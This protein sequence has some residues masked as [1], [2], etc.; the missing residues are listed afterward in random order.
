MDHLLQLSIQINPRDEDFCQP[1][2]ARS[3]PIFNFPL[4]SFLMRVCVALAT[5]VLLLP[6]YSIMYKMTY[7][8][9]FSTTF[10]LSCMIFSS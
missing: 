5:N 10:S 1:F 2:A 6:I 4:F 8:N 9:G 7:P 3:W